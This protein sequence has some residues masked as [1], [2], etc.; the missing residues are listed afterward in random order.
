MTVHPASSQVP[1]LNDCLETGPPLQPRIFDILLRNRMRK[2]CITSDV[3]KAFLQ[4][5]LN[6][7]DRDAQRLSGIIT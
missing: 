3:K 7:A 6:P 1:S 4:I 5:K 2:S